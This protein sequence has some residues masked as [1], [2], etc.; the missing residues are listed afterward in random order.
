M[1]PSSSV[2]FIRMSTSASTSKIEPKIGEPLNDE[3]RDTKKKLADTQN[4]LE[5]MKASHAEKLKK[6][7]ASH[8]DTQKELNKMQA[9]QVCTHVFFVLV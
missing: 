1:E 3:L 6:M 7:K 9:Y 2:D 8:A 4:E 5:K